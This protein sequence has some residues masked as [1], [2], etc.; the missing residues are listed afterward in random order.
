MTRTDIPPKGFYTQKLPGHIDRVIYST[1][2]TRG[3][4]WIE[5]MYAQ[6]SWMG[7]MWH[8][9]DDIDLSTHTLTN[10]CKYKLK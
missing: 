3:N 4:K 8:A 7:L 6:P 10:P 1:G 9:M 2:T 5:L